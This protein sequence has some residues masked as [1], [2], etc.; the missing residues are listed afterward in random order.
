VVFNVVEGPK[1]K[2]ATLRFSA[3]RHSRSG[4]WF[5]HEEHA[6]YGIPDSILFEDLFPLLTTPPNWK[7]TKSVSAT[8]T[9]RKAISQPKPWIR[10]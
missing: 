8:P 1:I 2:V 3:T 10:P 4:K 9:R 5:A 7:R 6:P